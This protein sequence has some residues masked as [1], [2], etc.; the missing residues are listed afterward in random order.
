MPRLAYLHRY[1][2]DLDFRYNRRAAL[3]I[4]DVDAPKD[5]LRKTRDNCL[6]HRRVAQGQSR[7][8]RKRLFYFARIMPVETGHRDI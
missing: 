7:L 5:Y 1:L 2:A 8:N 4:S 6:I 3:I